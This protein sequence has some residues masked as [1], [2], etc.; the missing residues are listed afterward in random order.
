[1]A[2]REKAWRRGPG[3]YEKG[4]GG[5]RPGLFGFIRRVDQTE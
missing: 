3:G 5:V 1:M 4:R 2:P